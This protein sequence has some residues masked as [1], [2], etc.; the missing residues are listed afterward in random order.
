MTTAVPTKINGAL[1]R[2]RAIAYVVGVGLLV[3]VLIG[4]PMEYLPA[5]KDK[6]V[7][8]VVGPVHGV[9]YM[10]YI[11]LAF[12]LSIKS[13]WSPKGTILVLLAGTIP[14]LS[15]VAERIVTRKVKAG[16]KL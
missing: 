6:T 15:F 12:D 11:A 13:K 14:F 5:I 8:S 2:F 9:L 16:E 1:K 4:V 3:L 7:V 10:V